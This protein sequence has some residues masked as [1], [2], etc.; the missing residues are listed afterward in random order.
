[1]TNRVPLQVVDKLEAGSAAA[2]H[3]GLSFVKGDFFKALP[4]ELA[5]S[6]AVLMKFILH[7]WGDEDCGRILANVRGCLASGGRSRLV[8]V[9]LVVPQGP[10]GRSAMPVLALDLDMM[11][12]CVRGR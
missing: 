3:P 11:Q 9:E 10:F 12:V 8:L 2:T 6:D 5:G 1:M 4:V 7:D